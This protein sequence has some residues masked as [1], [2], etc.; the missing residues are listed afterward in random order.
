LFRGIGSWDAQGIVRAYSLA[1]WI[2]RW[3]QW[4]VSGPIRHQPSGPMGI[5]CALGEVQCMAVPEVGRYRTE[6]RRRNHAERAIRQTR[7]AK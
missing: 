2:N 1:R 3:F 5:R 7:I 6:R 4:P